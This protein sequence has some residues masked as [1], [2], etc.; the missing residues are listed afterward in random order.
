MTQLKIRIDSDHYCS[1]CKKIVSESFLIHTD[2]I[3]E[4]YLRHSIFRRTF[5]A[6][7][8]RGFL[9]QTNN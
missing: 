1:K 2:M 5:A 3:N 8:F 6:M 7:N 9:C 4:S